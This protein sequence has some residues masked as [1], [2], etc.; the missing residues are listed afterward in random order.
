MD[1]KMCYFCTNEAFSPKFCYSCQ[2][3]TDVEVCKIKAC[4]VRAIEL[5]R[6]EQHQSIDIV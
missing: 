2:S 3:L 6:E 1:F 5:H 4:Q